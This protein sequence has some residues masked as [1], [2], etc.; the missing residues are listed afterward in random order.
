MGF[1]DARPFVW[2]NLVGQLGNQMFQIAAAV[3]V[4]LDHDADA[5]FPDLIEKTEYNIPLNYKHVFF[6]LN[7]TRPKEPVAFVYMDPNCP[8][9]PIPFHPNMKIGWWLQSEKYFCHH[10]EAILDLFEPSEAIKEHLA[11]HYAQYYS[12]SNSVAV[13]F[14]SYLIED[15]SQRFHNTL[16]KA[17]YEKAFMHF[18]E[19]ALFIVCSN[20]VSWCKK[21]FADIPRIFIFIENEPYYHDFYLMSMCKH[22]IISNSLFSWW[23]AYLNKNPQ[24]IVIA[25]PKWFADTSGQDYRDVVPESWTI[26]SR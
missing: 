1:I 16:D 22:N 20:D 5:V 21:A 12:H 13:H 8:Y 10:K 15:P 23:S 11:T 7:A 17:Y 18:P 26:L 24:K 6:R 25:P 2:G 9:T 3:S 4:A 19:D 14:R